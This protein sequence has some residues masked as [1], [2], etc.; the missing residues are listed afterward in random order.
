MVSEYTGLNF[1]EIDDL[2]CFEYWLYLRDS[3]IYNKSSYQEGREYLEK[4]W[5]LEQD[6]QDR[7][8]LR[9]L[10]GKK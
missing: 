2:D 10:F 1:K 4:C 6:K 7:N 9:R 5:F 8:T 3:F